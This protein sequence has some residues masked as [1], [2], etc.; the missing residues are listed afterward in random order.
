MGLITA[1]LAVCGRR[2]FVAL[3]ALIGSTVVYA[4]AIGQINLAHLPDKLS[5]TQRYQ[6][7]YRT[8]F[9][10]TESTYNQLQKLGYKE[11]LQR[12]FSLPAS[13]H[14]KLFLTFD[15]PESHKVRGNVW[16]QI[17]IYSEDQLRQRMAFALSEIFVV[18]RLGGGLGKKAHS[19][20]NYYD[21]LAEN[22]FSNYRQLLEKVTFHPAMGRYLSMMGSRKADADKGTF[23]DENYAR[24]VMQLF[25]IGL[26]QLNNDGSYKTSAN[27]ELVP[28]YTQS[29]VEEVA[30]A[31]SGWVREKSDK[32]LLKPMRAVSSRHDF[33]EKRVLG[34]TLKSGQTPYQDV[35]QILDILFYHPNT[36]A[37]VSKQLIKRFVTS[38]PS[39][40]YVQRI[41]SVFADNGKGERGD[42]K[43][44]LLAILLDQEALGYSQLKP[45]KVKE[46]LLALT[47]IYRVFSV[48]EA[49][50]GAK[51]TLFYRAAQQGP[52]SS[53]SVFNFF[54]PDYQPATFMQQGEMVAPELEL[55]NWTSYTAY[56]NAARAILY[57]VNKADSPLS[58]DEYTG[59]KDKPEQLTELINKR[60]FANKMS[61]ELKSIIK[62]NLSGNSKRKQNRVL[63]SLY[64]ALISDEFL[65]QE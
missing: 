16:W 38:N 9:G 25:T 34:H 8:T 39:D 21:L 17:A 53:P 55:M 7:L 58:V 28:S 10:P 61:A 2:L 57:S 54:E 18:S 43:S 6:L 5:E 59:L 20:S 31:F 14:E 42:L 56:S 40:E 52:L 19:L 47:N 15:E 30:R 12:Q 29:D 36:A 46:P 37:F 4:G 45:V 1:F 13:S 35:S 60:L 51:A 48:G 27:G 24:E 50:S 62:D 64:L 63:Q 22:A 26:Y 23:P 49:E 11:W 3:A 65:I 32:A 41:S 44:V 33:T